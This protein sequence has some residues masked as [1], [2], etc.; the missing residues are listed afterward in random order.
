[1]KEAAKH[2]EPRRAVLLCRS[3][4]GVSEYQ[5]MRLLGGGGEDGE[6]ERGLDPVVGIGEPARRATPAGAVPIGQQSESTLPTLLYLQRLTSLIHAHRGTVPPDKHVSLAEGPL[7]GSRRRPE[8]S[9]GI[10]FPAV[11]PDTR[12]STAI[13]PQVESLRGF[14][15]TLYARRKGNLRNTP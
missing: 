10:V 11:A 4:K 7:P 8:V 15:A 5:M 2:G 6:P 3:G 14:V 9:A 12:R 13:R 1:M